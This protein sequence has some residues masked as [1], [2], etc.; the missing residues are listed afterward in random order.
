MCELR[1]SLRLKSEDN[2]RLKMI[3]DD[4]N[5]NLKSYRLENEMLREKLN[6]LKSEFYR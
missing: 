1:L 4:T 5:N 2:E 3:Q 6:I